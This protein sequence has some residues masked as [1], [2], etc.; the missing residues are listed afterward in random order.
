MV[1]SFN[2]VTQSDFLVV[3]LVAVLARVSDGQMYARSMI[4]QRV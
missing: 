4:S 1:N 2:V 3:R